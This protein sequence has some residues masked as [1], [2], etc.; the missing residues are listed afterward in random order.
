M[1]VNTL[2]W[3]ESFNVSAALDEKFPEDIFGG[4]GYVSGRD[5]D[6]RPVT[7]VICFLSVLCNQLTV[8]LHEATISTEEVRTSKLFFLISRDSFGTN[9]FNYVFRP[10]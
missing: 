8:I 10:S 7:Y 1:L 9:T 5:K 2:R 3:R 4:L 6:G